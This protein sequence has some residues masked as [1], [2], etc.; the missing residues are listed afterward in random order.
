[1]KIWVSLFL[2]T[3]LCVI[4]L[5]GVSAQTGGEVVVNGAVTNHT[6]GGGI[7]AD[8]PVTLQFFSDSAWTSIYT[9]TIKNDGTFGFTGL[10]HRI[11]E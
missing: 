3:F 2:G 8:A 10:R 1:M 9:S 4:G 11:G 5:S 6:P 7:P